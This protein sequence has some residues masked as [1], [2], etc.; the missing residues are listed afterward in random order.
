M[1]ALLCPDCSI[2]M[3]VKRYYGVAVDICPACAGVWFDE[4]E[5]KALMQVDPLI[6]LSLE[7][8]AVPDV[9]Y[10]DEETVDRRCP[11]CAIALHPYRYMYDSPIELDGCNQCHGIWVENGELRHIHEELMARRASEPGEEE[12][13][14]VAIAQYALE[15]QEQVDRAN[16]LTSL[17][18]LLRKRVPPF[19]GFGS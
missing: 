9:V 13:R 2:E 3:E 6:L 16:M 4:S 11:R 15:S 18:S 12:R 1:N 14:R 17:F 19:S 5:L 7:D 8:R 10:A